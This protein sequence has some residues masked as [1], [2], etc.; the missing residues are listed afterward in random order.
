MCSA[1]CRCQAEG[2]DEGAAD[3]TGAM[4]GRIRGLHR[5]PLPTPLPWRGSAGEEGQECRHASPLCEVVSLRSHRNGQGPPEPRGRMSFLRNRPW[6]ELA[7][8]ARSLWGRALG[9]GWGQAAA[10]R[11]LT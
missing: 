5:E 11:S 10:G 2:H 1:L 3:F 8:P 4:G 9:L 7:V 6:T